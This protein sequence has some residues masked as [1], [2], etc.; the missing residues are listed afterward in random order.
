MACSGGADSSALAVA[1]SAAA[2]DLVIAHVVHDLRPPAER[3]ADRDA[4]RDLARRLGVE[5]VEA[6]IR[7]GAAGGNA[8]A[9]A[10][11]M[12]YRALARLS[13][14]CGCRF[15]ATAHHAD[16]QLETVLMA[17]LRGAGPSG[18]AGIARRRPLRPD[19]STGRT[20][21]EGP[22]LIR[23]MLGV[24]RAE[25]RSL[26]REAGVTWSEDRTNADGRRLRAALRARV[27]PVL[28]ELRP[29]TSLRASRAA[30]LM[31]GT[32]AALRASARDAFAAAGEEQGDY[33][34]RRAT[35]RRLRPV[36]LGAGLR[37]MFAGLTGGERLDRLSSRSVDA[38]VRAIRSTSTDPRTI[39]F[40]GGVRVG[41]TA[42]TVTIS[43]ER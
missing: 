34:W 15:I 42:S 20:I 8:E 2:R 39:E 12:R 13:M 36:L 18:L 23:P 10:R 31:R 35:L 22:I 40:P 5:F 32:G 1:L 11:A 9:T 28:E 14:R 26:C 25:A 38:A 16:D 37:D 7:P 21:E 33:S 24:T 30:E 27:L 4:A 3:L 17:L 29:G 6:H 43:R 19:G 41:I